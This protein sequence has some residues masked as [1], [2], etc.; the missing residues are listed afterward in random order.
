MFLEKKQKTKVA[1]VSLETYLFAKEECK[2]WL[3]CYAFNGTQTF[4]F[5]LANVSNGAFF[6]IMLNYCVANYHNAYAP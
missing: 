5:C 4:L 1:I 6:L 3:I 2:L